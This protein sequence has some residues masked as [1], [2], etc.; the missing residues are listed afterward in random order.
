M[1]CN[2]QNLAF[3]LFLRPVLGDVQRV[4][5]LFESNNVYQTKLAIDLSTLIVLLGK[6]IVLPSF[7]FKPI[8]NGN[9]IDHLHP[10]PFLVYSFENS[11]RT[12]K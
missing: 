4:N 1:Y 9:F 2:E 8:T 6:L 11:D 7:H 5:K 10:K 12:K 3:F